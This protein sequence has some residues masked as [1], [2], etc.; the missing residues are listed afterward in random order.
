MGKVAVAR[1]EG[2]GEEAID[3]L[4]A[5]KGFADLVETYRNLIE[6]P[7]EAS[8]KRL[9]VGT[10]MEREPAAGITLARSSRTL[11]GSVDPRL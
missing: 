5:P 7:A 9:G 1:A 3:A 11:G 4:L 2:R 8:I 6:Q 10:R